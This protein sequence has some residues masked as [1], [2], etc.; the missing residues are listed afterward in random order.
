MIGAYIALVLGVVVWVALVPMG[1]RLSEK[2]MHRITVFGGAFLLAV[3]FV[4]LLPEAVCIQ[5]L[6]GSEASV[7]LWPFLAVLVGF[8]VQQ[9]LDG[10]SAHAEHG[11]TEEGFTLTGLM[12]GLSLHALLEGMPIVGVD[13]TVNWGL[14]IGI[15]IHNIPV[16]LIL[17]GLMTARGMGMGK[18]LL[19]LTLFA[20]MTPIGSLLEVLVLQPEGLWRCV[21]VGVVVGVL[22]HV[23]SSILF[24]HKRNHFSW[25]NL[26]IIVLAFAL[27]MLTIH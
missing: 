4:G 6:H 27:A 7:S 25:L 10:I 19:L 20:L 23:S 24:D 18:V 16:A 5:E 14:V 22:L 1:K 8:L 13:G 12:I 15:V 11:H 21:I 9:V 2:V 17:V 3:C 26:G